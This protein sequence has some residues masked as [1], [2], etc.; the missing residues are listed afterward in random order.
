MLKKRSVVMRI[1]ERRRKN[2]EFF[3]RI[4]NSLK[5]IISR[6]IEILA[7]PIEAF[8]EWIDRGYKEG[9]EDGLNTTVKVVVNETLDIIH[10]RADVIKERCN[11]IL[12]VISDI[13]LQDPGLR[14]EVE[15][16]EGS[17]QEILKQIN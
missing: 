4:G 9:Y 6:S 11:W 17:V 16:I 3:E 15:S 5:R 12:A 7:K 2:R 8:D 13:E 10:E 1:S 14:T